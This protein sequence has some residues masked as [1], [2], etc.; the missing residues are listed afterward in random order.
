MPPVPSTR[1][2]AVAVAP[3]CAASPTSSLAP[4]TVSVLVV[5]APF[6]MTVPELTL[7]AFT[8]GDRVGIGE[9]P[10]AEREVDGVARSRADDVAGDRAAHD[11]EDVGEGRQPDRARD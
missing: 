6:R 8:S 3:G 4:V 1:L 9:R 5:S 10:G 2:V 11:V 7:T